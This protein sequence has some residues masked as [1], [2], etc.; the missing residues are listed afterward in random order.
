MGTESGTRKHSVVG[1]RNLAEMIMNL[2]IDHWK[3]RD[4][5]F[6]DWLIEQLPDDI[7]VSEPGF[8]S[9]SDS[10]EVSLSHPFI[11]ECAGI[12]LRATRQ[13]LLMISG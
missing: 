12:S 8:T 10:Q 13:A 1:N 11:L 3:V 6:S 5:Q 4:R 2:I 7:T 9:V